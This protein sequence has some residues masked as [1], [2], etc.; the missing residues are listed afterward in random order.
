MILHL[1]LICA[2]FTSSFAYSNQDSSNIAI[3]SD[4]DDDYDYSNIE[5]DLRL[6]EEDRLHSY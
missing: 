2:L 4:E 6:L 5:D 1:G 3:E